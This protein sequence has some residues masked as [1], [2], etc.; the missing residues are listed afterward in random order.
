MYTWRRFFLRIVGRLEPLFHVSELLQVRFYAEGTKI[1][2]P[3]NCGFLA[4]TNV[5]S[6]R[7]TVV[8]ERKSEIKLAACKVHKPKT[9]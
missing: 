9:S 2:K 8:A 4:I 1:L 5:L 3:D 6:Q 7:V